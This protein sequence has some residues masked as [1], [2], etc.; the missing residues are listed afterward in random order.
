VDFLVIIKTSFLDMFE[1]KTYRLSKQGLQ[2][3]PYQPLINNELQYAEGEEGFLWVR[4]VKP[5]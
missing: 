1:I 5:K 2:N 4:A 3:S